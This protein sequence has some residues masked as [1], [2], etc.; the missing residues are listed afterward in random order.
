[1]I[2]YIRIELDKIK[3]KNCTCIMLAIAL[4]ITILGIYF[5]HSINKS[6]NALG[7]SVNPF[8][9]DGVPGIIDVL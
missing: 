6:N 5:Y 9:Y 1:M 4:V 8:S 2:K 7:I 3:K